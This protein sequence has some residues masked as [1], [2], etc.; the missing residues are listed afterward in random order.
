[1]GEELIG[2]ILDYLK[3]EQKKSKEEKD[4]ENFQ[5]KN[6][7]KTF[8]RLISSLFEN[9]IIDKPYH[10]YLENK[11]SPEEALEE[12][13]RLFTKLEELRAQEDLW[14]FF[15]GWKTDYSLE[16]RQKIW[17]IV[18]KHSGFWGEFKKEESSPREFPNY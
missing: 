7:L 12:L 14:I 10:S 13:K 5:R 4:Q 1:M 16:N 2:E 18:L 11:L 17:E 3:S 15:S 9:L 6:L 8:F